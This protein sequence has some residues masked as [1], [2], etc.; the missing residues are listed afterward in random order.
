[1]VLVE[2]IVAGLFSLESLSK[3]ENLVLTLIS[4]CRFWGG[5][6][7]YTQSLN[8]TKYHF[9]GKNLKKVDR[10]NLGFLRETFEIAGW[11]SNNLVFL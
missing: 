7:Y 9:F 5:Q 2:V 11:V 8:L 6:D 1:M 3:S 4:L 10:R